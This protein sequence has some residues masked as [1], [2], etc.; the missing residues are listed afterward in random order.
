MVFPIVA[1]PVYLPINSAQYFS[2]FP[3]L[4]HQHLLFLFI[5]CVCVCVCVVFLM[6]AILTGVR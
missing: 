2:F 6:I 4:S 1:A 3:L 5:L